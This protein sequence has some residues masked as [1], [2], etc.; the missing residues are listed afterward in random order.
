MS[1]N[2]LDNQ[3]QSTSQTHINENLLTQPSAWTQTHTPT[4]NI[5]ID[6]IV[7][8]AQEL[9]KIPSIAGDTGKAVEVLQYI[10]KQLPDSNFTAYA[11]AGIPSLLYSNRGPH[12]KKFK[13]LFNAHLDVVPAAPNQFVPYIKDG[14]IYGRGAYDMKAASAVKLIL[15]RELADDLPYPIAL[16]FTTDEELGGLNGTAY[17]V[18]QGVRSDFVITGECGSNFGIVHEA[19]GMLHLKLIAKGKS[20]HSA[21]PWNGENAIV[22]IYQALS[23][24]YKAY[25]MPKE[26][27]YRTTLNVTHIQTTN[28]PKH[29]MTPDNCEALLDVRYLPQEKKTILQDIQKLLP[30]GVTT[31]V[32]FHTTPHETDKDSTYIKSLQ[33]IGRNVLHKDLELRQQHATSDARYYSTVNNDAVEFGPVGQGQ[34]YDAEWVDIQSL[35]D[36]YQILKKF[37]L[38]IK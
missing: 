23:E 17:Q 8:L 7:D 20:S 31:E 2:K 32:V 14:R 9:I 16:Q 18:K 22:K 35:A 15:F 19:K 3:L 37:L 21:Y 34:H 24:I 30:E 12:E 38:S 10:E 4:A 33:S 1:S 6:E 26:P 11:S 36:Y 29:T 25:P 13:V 28:S 5:P 27:M